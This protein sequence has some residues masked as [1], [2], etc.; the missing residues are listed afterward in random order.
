MEVRLS[1][2]NA[3]ENKINDP[4]AS[5]RVSKDNEREASL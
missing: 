3:L 1:G 4:A 5:S 2:R